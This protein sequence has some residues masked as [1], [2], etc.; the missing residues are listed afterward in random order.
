MLYMLLNNKSLTVNVLWYYSLVGNLFRQKWL[1]AYLLKFDV[2]I[3]SC[4]LMMQEL[5]I[6]YMLDRKVTNYYYRTCIAASFLLWKAHYTCTKFQG[7][8]L[9]KQ[10]YCLNFASIK[11]QRGPWLFLKQEMYLDASLLLSSTM[12]VY[13]SK[14]FNMITNVCS[15]KH[16]R[17]FS[18]KIMN[19]RLLNTVILLRT[20]N[21]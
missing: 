11:W 6:V 9:S 20:L 17:M 7:L 5:W 10:C 14:N 12:Y 15:S 4:K 8:H 3:C 21:I 13:K 2:R 16:K 18:L 19:I 1:A